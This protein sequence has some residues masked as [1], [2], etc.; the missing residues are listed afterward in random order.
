MEKI[1]FLTKVLML[2][3]ATVLP[4]TGIRKTKIWQKT[5]SILLIASYCILCILFMANNKTFNYPFWM[6]LIV[7]FI[8]VIWAMY[9]SI[10]KAEP[11]KDDIANEKTL[12]N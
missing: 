8:P 11:M 7:S 1:L 6:V 9:M 10:Q 4:L 2:A 12:I 3:F 5:T